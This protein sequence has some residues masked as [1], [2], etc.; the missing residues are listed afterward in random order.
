M[1][2]HKTYPAAIAA[3][4]IF[5]L[6]SEPG[7]ASDSWEN[8]KKEWKTIQSDWTLVAMTPG[9]DE[10]QMNFAWY[11]KKGADVSFRFGQKRDLSD[12]KSVKIRQSKAQRGYRSNQVTLTGLKPGSTYY[13]QADKKEIRSFRTNESGDDFSFIYVGDPQIG[14]SNPVRAI[15]NGDITEKFLSAQNDAVRNDAFHWNASLESAYQ[16]SDR[17]ADFILSAGDQIQTKA[18]KLKDE[19]LSEIEYAGFLS[20]DL[21]GSIPLAPTVGSHDDDNPNFDYHFH[22]PNQSKLGENEFVGGDYWFTYGNA[23]FLMLNTQDNNTAEHREFIEDAIRKNPECVW[24]IVT[25]HQDIYGS[26]KHSIEEKIKELRYQLLPYLEENDIDV[27]LTGHDHSYTRSVFLKGDRKTDD[28]PVSGKVTNPDGILYMTASSSSG[29]KYYELTPQTQP[30]VAA[31]WQREVPTY[32]IVN[33]TKN[34]FRITTY[35]AD[36]GKRIDDPLTILK[37]TDDK[38]IAKTSVNP[39]EATAYTGKEISPAITV[40]LNGTALKMGT[41]YTVSFSDNTE[42]GAATATIT[43]I[44]SYSGTKTVSFSIVP[45]QIK[46]T[47]AR[48]NKKKSITVTYRQAQIP[49]SG[50]QIVYARNS[51][52]W[53]AKKEKTQKTTCRLKSLKKGKTYYIKVRGYKDVSGRTYYGEYSKIYK[54][55]VKK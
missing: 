42:I 44:G 11:S 54:V 45:P 28:V 1:R 4:M 18:Q 17:K 21:L 33:V 2:K 15:E 38:N 29:S 48:S 25:L 19:T 23:L 27:V 39:I 37:N 6:L 36:N 52:F 51:R 50:Y 10:S 34:K 24:R 32:S 43:G 35:R 26:A 8:W 30:Y 41:D 49:L 20:P 53:D 22:V 55:K 7:F 47:S 14:S 3:A 16:K 12:G 46:V 5:F 40:R 13:Y 9:C 31:R